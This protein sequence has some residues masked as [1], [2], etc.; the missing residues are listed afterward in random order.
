[1][2]EKRT[3]RGRPPYGSPK[4]TP[5]VKFGVSLPPEVHERLAKYCEDEEREKSW[6]IKKALEAWLTEK[7]Y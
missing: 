4:K 2:T 3:N 1:M 6:C 5:F 7:G